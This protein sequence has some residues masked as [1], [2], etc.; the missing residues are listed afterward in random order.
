[1]APLAGSAVLAPFMN[2]NI[3]APP[4]QKVDDDDLS[5]AVGILVS[6]LLSGLFWLA[7]GLIL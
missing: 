6:V 5:P 4:G 7:L 2:G 1:M 3:P